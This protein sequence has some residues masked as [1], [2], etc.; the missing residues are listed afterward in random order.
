MECKVTTDDGDGARSYIG[1]TVCDG[2]GQHRLILTRPYQDAG[3]VVE[4]P[5]AD[6]EAVEPFEGPSSIDSRARQS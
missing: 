2:P 3:H 1:I 4:I 6:I 5:T